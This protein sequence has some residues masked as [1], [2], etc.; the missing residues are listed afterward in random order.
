MCLVVLQQLFPGYFLEYS[1]TP[2]DRPMM[3]FRSKI[4]KEFSHDQLQGSSLRIRISSKTTS[5][6]L[7]HFPGV[8]CGM[9]I[10]VK[11]DIQRFLDL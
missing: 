9:E 11:L 5:F 4:S 2:Y 8:K 3:G 7:P 10:C 1:H 6:S